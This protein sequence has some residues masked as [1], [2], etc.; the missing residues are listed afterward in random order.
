MCIFGLTYSTFLIM[1]TFLLIP[2]LKRV[3]NNMHTPTFSWWSWMFWK[4]HYGNLRFGFPLIR[5]KCFCCRA[6]K[7]RWAWILS[8]KTLS[9]KAKYF[10]LQNIKKCLSIS[11]VGIA[12]ILILLANP[13]YTFQ[14][15]ITFPKILYSWMFYS[16]AFYFLQLTNA[17]KL[18]LK[19]F[20][21][22]YNE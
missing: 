4:S 8:D 14:W 1:Q 10:Y 3:D 6:N 7:L 21:T 16:N 18:F 13:L 9:F 22:A 19:I 17:S 12:T 20:L 15:G 11:V 5:L 2:V